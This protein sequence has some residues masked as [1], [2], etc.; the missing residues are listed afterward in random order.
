LLGLL[1]DPEDGG[2]T[3]LGNA[4]TSIGLHGFTAQNVALFIG[5]AVRT[6]K[7]TLSYRPI[8]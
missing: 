1:F 2:N 4:G 6:W 3:F 8:A 5:S 7:S